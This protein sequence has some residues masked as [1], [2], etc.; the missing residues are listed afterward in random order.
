MNML[1]PALIGA[2]LIGALACPDAWS[3]GHGRGG[4]QFSGSHSSGHMRSGH[5][6]GSGYSHGGGHYRGHGYVRGGVIVGAPLFWPY[7]YGDPYYYYPGYY[8]DAPVYLPPDDAV[9][10]PGSAAGVLYYCDSPRGYYPRIGSCRV[11]W[12][13]VA[14]TRVPPP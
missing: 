7:W 13:A 9:V 2:L 8:V 4:G 1:K 14:A 10:Y 6:G 3:Q 11:P 12:R 5:A